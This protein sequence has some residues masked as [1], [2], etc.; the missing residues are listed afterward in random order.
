M[1]GLVS[2][3]I[4]AYN[5]ERYIK[6]SLDSALVQTY[7]NIEIIIVDD[8]SID[9]TRRVLDPYIEKKN[10]KYIFQLHQGLPSA[11]NTAIRN[12]Q[13]EYIAFLDADDIFAPTKIERQVEHLEKNP[14]CDVSYCDLYHFFDDRPG[15]LFK[16]DYH[17]YSGKDFL[18]NILRYFFIAPLTVVLRRSVF[19]RF[20]YFDESF[21]VAEDLDFWLKVAYRGGR[22]CFLPEIL[23]KLRLRQKGNIQTLEDQPRLKL[24][25]LRGVEKLNSEMR[26]EERQRYRM[27]FHLMRYRLKVAFAYLL[28]GNKNDAQ[29]FVALAFQDYSLGFFVNRLYFLSLFAIPTPWVRK[30]ARFIYRVRRNLVLKKV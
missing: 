22:I 9:S 2:V 5:V 18:P 11:R 17:Y 10:I 21:V 23:G 19:E 4:P 26:E 25:A 27:Q 13:G 6:E 8:G 24:M 30:L 7:R 15:Q 14:D 3:I 1:K 28:V 29:K 12:S 20:G 16:L